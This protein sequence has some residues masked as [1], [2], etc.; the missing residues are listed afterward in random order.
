MFPM[1]PEHETPDRRRWDD[2][3]DVLRSKLAETFASKAEV[4]SVK[5]DQAKQ[6]VD[7]AVLKTELHGI[8]IAVEKLSSHMER[9]AWIVLTAVILAVAGLVL[10]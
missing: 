1:P 7:M 3:V 9:A 5:A 8:R 6:N 2:L 4:A 10:I